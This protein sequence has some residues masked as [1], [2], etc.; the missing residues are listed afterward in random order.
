[1]DVAARRLQ[2]TGDSGRAPVTGPGYRRIENQ[3]TFH[4]VETES[5]HLA[6]QTKHAM[7]FCGM[8]EEPLDS[9]DER[10]VM[11]VSPSKAGEGRLP[12]TNTKFPNTTA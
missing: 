11:I 7:F 4:S 5:E 2:G 8:K 1:M 3:F 10:V 6:E 12:L 9:E